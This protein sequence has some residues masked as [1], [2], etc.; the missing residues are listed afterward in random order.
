MF[1]FLFDTIREAL[2]LLAGAFVGWNVPRPEWA[3]KL[4]AVVI[5]KYNELAAK[6]KTKFSR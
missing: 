3:K 6:I 1:E 5:A 2:F 4:Q